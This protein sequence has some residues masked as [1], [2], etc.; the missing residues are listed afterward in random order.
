MS[1][2]VVAVVEA[3]AVAVVVEPAAV[4]DDNTFAAEG[5]ADLGCIGEG[6]PTF[7]EHF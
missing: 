4:T 1:T 3:V 2:T 6:L 5:D 7:K